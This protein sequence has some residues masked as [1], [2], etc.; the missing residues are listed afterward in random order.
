M[1][2]TLLAIATQ[3][4]ALMERMQNVVSTRP[5]A[6]KPTASVTGRWLIHFSFRGAEPC[7]MHGVL[8]RSNP[9][10]RWSATAFSD[11]AMGGLGPAR[12]LSRTAPAGGWLPSPTAAP[13]S[14]YDPVIVRAIPAGTLNRRP[15]PGY[16][17]WCKAHR[18][19]AW[20]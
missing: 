16:Q 3:R 14:R 17:T 12:Q 6:T 9:S 18:V 11:R 13:F 2:A 10:A 1:K 4:S 15:R 8:S 19:G 20:P 7:E 5:A